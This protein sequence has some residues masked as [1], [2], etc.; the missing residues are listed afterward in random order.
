MI[1]I[2]CDIGERET[3]NPVDLALMGRIHIANIAC[4]GHAGNAETVRVFRA[5]ADKLHVAVSAHLSYP[6]KVDFGRKS[7]D[8]D[9]GELIDSLDG[10]FSLMPGVTMVK[11]HGGLYHDSSGRPFLAK[12]LAGWLKKRDVETLIA[13]MGSEIQKACENIGIHVL[14]E[15]FAE[16]R[17]HYDSETG[18]LG[19]MDR[20]EALAS[21]TDSNEAMR[22]C[23]NLI[24]YGFVEAYSGNGKG[25]WI[26]KNVTLPCRTLCIHSDSHIALTLAG[27]LSLTL[28]NELPVHD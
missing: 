13:P 18:K 2:N 5:L 15:A 16:R 6:D 26:K 9:D 22:Q 27:S 21:I 19:L 17:Y 24:R 4:G 7:M 1:R 23:L 10:Q 25:G 20:C 14:Y 28:R 12:V 11:F 3:D 8:M